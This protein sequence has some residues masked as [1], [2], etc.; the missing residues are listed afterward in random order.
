VPPELRKPFWLIPNLL[1]LDAPLVAVAWL[2]IFARTW[3]VQYLPWSAYFSLGLVV[4]VIYVTD[5]LVDASM[6]GG[7]SG[8]LKARHE[9]HRAHQKLFRW[10]A[11]IASVLALILV[12]VPIK[13]SIF[14]QPFDTGL[15]VK[16]Y[17]FAVFGMLLVAGFF[18][19][20]F[21][22]SHGPDEIPYAKNLLAGLSF[23]YG[24]AMLASVFAGF[25]MNEF[26]RSRELIC[27]AVLCVL[28]ISAID[29]WE[30]AH[31]SSDP[32]I[33]ATDELALTLPLILLGAAALVFALQDRDLTT[34]PFFYSIL[35]GAA[36][37][38]IL[39]RNRAKFSM[40][41]LRVLADA[42]LLVPWLVF[43]VSSRS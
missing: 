15:P 37:L 13:V 2:Y 12:T 17:S 4:W 43:V 30:H 36:L 38:Q 21:F 39:N 3:R 8:K 27:F 1:S 6:H 28:N 33:K 41:G 32:E 42:A 9:F 11:A 20:S 25:E 18:A 26:I 34:R 35:T 40:A 5:R 19:L 31:R 16:I 14:G 24:A 10:A 23:A 7:S 22:S 29:F